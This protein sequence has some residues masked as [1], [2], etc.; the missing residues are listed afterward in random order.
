M[1]LIGTTGINSGQ[2]KYA[3]LTFTPCGSPVSSPTSPGNVFHTH[4]SHHICKY[5]CGYESQ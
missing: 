2:F 1:K 3:A 5:V 4:H